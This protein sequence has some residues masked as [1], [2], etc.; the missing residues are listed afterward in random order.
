MSCDAN[1]SVRFVYEPRVR[2]NINHSNVKH[3][4]V[5]NRIYLHQQCPA[6]KGKGAQNTQRTTNMSLCLPLMFQR[7]VVLL[8][9]DS[10]LREQT[11][12][13]HWGE[14]TANVL[15]S[16][17][18]CVVINANV[19]NES[20][21]WQFTYWFE[22]YENDSLGDTRAVNRHCVRSN[23]ARLNNNSENEEGKNEGRKR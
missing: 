22:F 7:I 8:P 16:C 18:V 6:Q 1:E 21:D 5:K 15:S 17:Y 10:Q 12:N 3:D 23:A 2:N 20:R 13:Q 9:V 4:H 19:I 14:L 11:R